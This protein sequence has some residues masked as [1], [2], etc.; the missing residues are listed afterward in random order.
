[1]SQSSSTIGGNAVQCET[2]PKLRYGTLRL[3]DGRTLAYHEEGSGV[4]VIAL[5]GMG[6]SRLTWL[7]KKPLEQIC[8]GV[9][10]IAVDRPGYG[11]S[12]SPPFGYNYTSFVRDVEELA[13]ALQLPRFCVAGHSSGGPFVFALASL[14]PDRVAAAAAISSDPPYNHPQTPP[15][16]READEMSQPASLEPMGLYGKDPRE[17]AEGYRNYS[18]KSGLPAKAHAWKQGTDGWICDWS[19]ERLPYSFTMETIALGPRL[20]IWY[21]GEDVGV[22]KLG[23]PFLQSLVQGSQ[24]REVAGG[25]HGFK[26][27]PKHL[28]AILSELKASSGL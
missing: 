16:V 21:G 12:S 6:S 17:F 18:L 19:L 5:H 24:L 25:N 28:A 3:K 7:S 23:A 11:G 1:V 15:E 2:S 27:D 26:S 13:D 8:P 14:L 10:I 22:I 20:T 9:R 4:P